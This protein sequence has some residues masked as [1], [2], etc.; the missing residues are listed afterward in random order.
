[1]A[2]LLTE[3]LYVALWS[4][5]VGIQVSVLVVVPFWRDCSR[6]RAEP[7]PCSTGSAPLN[8][9]MFGSG[10]PPNEWQFS[11]YSWPSLGDKPCGAVVMLGGCGGTV[12]LIAI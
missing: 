11:W 8:Q 2:R 5:M 12:F 4:S 3:H 6:R 1:M 7:W 9:V 10:L